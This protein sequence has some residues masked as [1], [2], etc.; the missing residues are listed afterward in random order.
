MGQ[1]DIML[2][3]SQVNF[4]Q[5]YISTFKLF[6]VS[7]KYDPNLSVQK[8]Y[9]FFAHDP[10]FEDTRLYIECLKEAHTQLLHNYIYKG[11]VFHKMADDPLQSLDPE[12]GVPPLFVTLF[13]ELTEKQAYS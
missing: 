9:A 2:V 3:Q 12:F 11:F 5:I 13:N 6:E 8:L 4:R 1:K 7:W 10:E